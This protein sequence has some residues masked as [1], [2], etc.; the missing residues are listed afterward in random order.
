MDSVDGDL[1]ADGLEPSAFDGDST[2]DGSET[3]GATTVSFNAQQAGTYLRTGAATWAV[4]DWNAPSLY[5]QDCTNFVSRA[6][7]IGG[8]V[9]MK[10]SGDENHKSKDYWWRKPSN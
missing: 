1:T 10:G 2:D 3:T 5:D 6:I 4:S 8:D 9:R 7:D